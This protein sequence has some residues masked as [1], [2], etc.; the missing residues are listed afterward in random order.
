MGQSLL[1]LLKRQFRQAASSHN[2]A[3][4]TPFMC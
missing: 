1:F 3:Q 4:N 2:S